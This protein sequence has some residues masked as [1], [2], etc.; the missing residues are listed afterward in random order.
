[1]KQLL[2]EDYRAAFHLNMLEKKLLLFQRC[3]HQRYPTTTETAN[4]H[5]GAPLD[6]GHL[7]NLTSNGSGA[8]NLQLQVSLRLFSP[9]RKDL[10]SI[11]F[12]KNI[13]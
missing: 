9:K 13:Y 12:K 5:A 1:M 2:S 10:D 11:T 4:T 6:P 8:R 3:L 7:Q